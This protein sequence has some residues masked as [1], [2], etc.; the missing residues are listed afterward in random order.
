MMVITVLDKGWIMI[1]FPKKKTIIYIV[2]YPM[3]CC[4]MPQFCIASCTLA[5]VNQNISNQV[6][7]I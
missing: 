3:P 5:L 6:G 2:E 7:E 4:Y 1:T